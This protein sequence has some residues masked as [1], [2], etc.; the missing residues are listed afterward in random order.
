MTRCGLLICLLIVGAA[1]VAGCSSGPLAPYSWEGQGQNDIGGSYSVKLVFT[2]YGSKA[3]GNYY[4]HDAT[5]PSGNVD[6]TVHERDLSMVLTSAVPEG[7]SAEP[8][9]F[10]L[11]GS[12]DMKTLSGT[13]EPRDPTCLP[14]KG[15]WDLTRQD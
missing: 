3:Y 12:I 15:V 2:L 6:G 11:T 9:V 4:L 10:D 8:C 7:S 1:L 13:F 5:D 14:P